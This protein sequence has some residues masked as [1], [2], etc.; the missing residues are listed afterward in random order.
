MGKAIT[1]EAAAKQLIEQFAK[2]QLD[3]HFA[4]LRCERMAFI[5]HKTTSHHT[6]ARK[7]PGEA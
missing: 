2:K 7:R 6:G 4:C 1:K 3:G 5:A